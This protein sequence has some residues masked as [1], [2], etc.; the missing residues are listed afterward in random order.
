VHF[1][2]HYIFQT[3]GK[4]ASK[5]SSNILPHTTEIQASH[6]LSLKLHPGRVTERRLRLMDHWMQWK[7][8]HCRC[9]RRRWRRLEAEWV[10]SS[11]RSHCGRVDTRA[12]GR[13][14][15]CKCRRDHSSGTTPSTETNNYTTLA[16]RQTYTTITN[17]QLVRTRQNIL[18]TT[19]IISY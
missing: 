11:E 10:E 15:W 8:R 17:T 19:C 3:T 6:H 5:D 9:R 1:C 14:S 13:N 16:S 4:N 12:G 2:T 7:C 18:G